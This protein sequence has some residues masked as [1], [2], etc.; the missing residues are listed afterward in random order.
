M[1]F[2]IKIEE[3]INRGLFWLAAKI[4]KLLQRL[5]PPVLK[6]IW[7][8]WQTKKSLYLAKVRA[9]PA[10]AKA[11]FARKGELVKIDY[12]GVFT[13]AIEASKKVYESTKAH[14]PHKAVLLALAAPFIF[15]YQWPSSLKPVHFVLLFTFTTA[16]IFSIMGIALNAKRIAE[17]EFGG[18]RT[19]ASVQDEYIRP[20]YYKKNERSVSFNNFKIPVYVEAVGELRAVVIDFSVTASNRA[21]AHWLGKHEFELRDHLVLTIEPVIATFPMTDEGRVMLSEKIKSEINIF[22]ETHSIEGQIQEARIIYILA[23]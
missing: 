22:L 7:E 15:L 13:Q 18:D 17:K 2:L 6:K 21:T 4:M 19:P 20:N 23:H 8:K 1:S 10:E 3:L 5:C 14:S 12:K 11:L 16:S 9:L